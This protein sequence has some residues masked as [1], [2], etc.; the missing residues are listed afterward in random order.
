MKPGSLCTTLALVLLLLTACGHVEAP[1]DPPPPAQQPSDPGDGSTPDDPTPDD[2]DDGGVEGVAVILDTDYGI[3]VDDVG[4]LAVLQALADM[5]ETTILGVV[6]NVADPFSPPAIDVVNT[7]YGRPDI[8]IGLTDRPYYAEAYPYWREHSPRF[9]EGM[10]LNF[11]HNTPMDGSVPT[12]TEVYRE[13]LASQPDGS[14]TI[15]STGFLQN[16]SDLLNSGPD[17]HSPLDGRALIEQKVRELSLMGGHYPS[18]HNDLYLS[19]G[20][21][22]DSRYAIDVI[23][24]WPTVI[25]FNTGPT[26]HEVMNGATLT[27]TTPET[28]PVRYAYEQFFDGPSRSRNAWDLCSVL[29]AVRGLSGPEGQYFDVIETE[30]LTLNASGFNEWI[31][32]DD[33]R[34]HRLIRV[35]PEDE[36][37]AILEALLTQPP[38]NPAP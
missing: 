36:L 24:N 20:R 2:P 3:D 30:Q 17:E 16:L 6:S 14:V 25:N 28:N 18:S 35:M 29:Y 1:A 23:E 27:A 21:E 11:P 19:G 7:Y 12:A 31:Q 15:I 33:P 22:M 10:A 34:H 9:I 8:P 37:S 26:C 4:A 5:G 32:D 38:A 13:L